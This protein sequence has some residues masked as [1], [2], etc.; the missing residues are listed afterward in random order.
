MF[1]GV[2]KGDLNNGFTS[3]RGAIVILAT[4]TVS[5]STVAYGSLGVP[6]P[7]VSRV[8]LSSA[9]VGVVTSCTLIHSDLTSTVMGD[10]T[11][12]DVSR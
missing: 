10:N 11:E 4:V 8:A 7:V 1:I 6:G 2:N 3:A 9:M 5:D 12:L